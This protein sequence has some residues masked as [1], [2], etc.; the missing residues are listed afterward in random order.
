MQKFIGTGNLTRDVEK[1][2]DNLAKFTIAIPED[3]EKD[4]ERPVQFFTI[5]CWNKLA[6]N[7]LKYLTKGSKVLV[8]GKLQNRTYEQDGTKK[9]ITEILAKSIEFL[10]TKKDEPKLTPIDDDKNPF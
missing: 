6:E 7:C 5:I 8:E 4:G 3:Y 10:V 1:V 2:S 9:Y